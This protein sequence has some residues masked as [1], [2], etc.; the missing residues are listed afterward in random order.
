MIAKEAN[1]RFLV[2]FPW[3][4]HLTDTPMF[5]LEDFGA[6]KK[7][8][9][10]KKDIQKFCLISWIVIINIYNCNLPLRVYYYI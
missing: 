8:G 10:L 2:V 4:K 6:K 1:W 9:G 3:L 7:L 5:P